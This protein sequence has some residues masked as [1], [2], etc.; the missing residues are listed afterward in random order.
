MS[1]EFDK[2]WDK[3]DG[4]H[5]ALQA[6]ELAKCRAQAFAERLLAERECPNDLI[7]WGRAHGIPEFAKFTWQAGFMAGMRAAML[8]AEAQEPT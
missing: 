3:V 4:D 7:E 1:N 6:L 5:D 8:N 2:A